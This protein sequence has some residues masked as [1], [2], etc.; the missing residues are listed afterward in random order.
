MILILEGLQIKSLYRPLVLPKKLV[1]VH[2]RLY[3]QFLQ[4]DRVCHNLRLNDM[5]TSEQE[6]RFWVHYTFLS[7]YVHSTR[8]GLRRT[9]NLRQPVERDNVSNEAFRNL[10]LGYVA[11][12]QSLYIGILIDYF[13][14]KNPA[15]E[16]SHYERHIVELEPAS[17]YFW[18]IY[19]SPTPFDVEQSEYQKEWLR[20][21]RLP[22]P[23]GVLY[24]SDPIERAGKMLNQ[25]SV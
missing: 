15:A 24:Y 7:S 12:L 11:N 21:Q 10:I 20:L 17:N 18:F 19:N 1:D 25:S 2:K 5:L 3:G 8:K 16:L 6:D 14:E 9:S 22:V 13:K 4:I 23:D